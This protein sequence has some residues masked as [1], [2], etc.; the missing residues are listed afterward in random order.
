MER[1][2]LASFGSGGTTDSDSRP[3]YRVSTACDKI[4]SAE[5]QQDGRGGVA[6]LRKLLAETLTWSTS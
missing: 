6:Q 3:D 2:S 1:G 5:D 4:Q